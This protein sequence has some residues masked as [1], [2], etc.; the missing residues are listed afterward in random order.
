V[1]SLGKESSSAGATGRATEQG[2]LRVLLVE[3]DEGDALI[4][5]LLLEDSR[6]HVELTHVELLGEALPIARDFDCALLDLGLPDANGFEGLERLRAAADDLPILV[7]TGMSDEERGVAALAAGAQDYLVKGHVDGELLARSVRYAVERRRADLAQR[8]LT[9]ARIHAAENTRLERGLLPTP[10]VSDSA[11]PIATHYTPGRRRALLGGDFYDVV[12]NADGRLRAVIGD[13]SGHGPDEAA[14][15]V[16]LRIAWRTL[17]LSGIPDEPLLGRLQEVLD[18]ERYDP[19]VF[20][21]LTA[22]DVS[23]DRRTL[24]VRRAGHP[25]PLLLPAGAPPR[26]LMD[27][28]GGPPL[29]VVDDPQWPATTIELEPGWGL[30]LYTDGISEGRRRDGARLGEEGLA[31]IVAAAQAEHPADPT[32]MVRSVVARAEELNAGPLRDDVALVLLRT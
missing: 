17:V 21:T 30:L 5:R 20:T 25:A 26:P 32:A 15:G 16:C 31:E 10:L 7:L 2:P 28:S 23:P 13:V 12:E 11:P 6:V 29:G 14:V 3:D 9:L 4:V 18:A 8:Q 22:V 24:T 19:S 27:G 1:I